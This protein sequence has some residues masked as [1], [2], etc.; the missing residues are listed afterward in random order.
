MRLEA[1]LMVGICQDV[2]DVLCDT[3]EELLEEGIR[4][5]LICNGEIVDDV[6][7]H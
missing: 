3:E 2:E 4:D 5:L 1:A 7:A 6:E